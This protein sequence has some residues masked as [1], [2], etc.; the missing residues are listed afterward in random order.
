[1]YEVIIPT[2]P[3]RPEGYLKNLLATLLD[4]R[5]IVVNNNDNLAVKRNAGLLRSKNDIVVFCDD[6]NILSD[7]CLKHLY[8]AFDDPRVGVAGVVSCYNAKSFYVCDSGSY[9]NL[10]S[11]ITRDRFVNKIILDVYGYSIRPFP[12]DEVANVFA[13]RKSLFPE[14]CFFDSERFP[15]DLDEADLCLRVRRMGHKVVTVP[16][17]VAF[18]NS[19]TYS[20][21]PNFRREKNA[22]YMGRNKIFFQRKHLSPFQFT[23]YCVS[24]LPAFFIA[25]L[26]ILACRG[27]FSMARYFAK[28]TLNGIRGRTTNFL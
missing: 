12:V 10:F 25:Y 2:Y 23:L 28:G 21:I 7:S 27:K 1:M 14:L 15:T 18:H 8:S 22:Y 5:V 20:R 11:G 24:F 3:E 26:L 4:S 17:A 9:R 16:R 19:Q 13:V 6:D